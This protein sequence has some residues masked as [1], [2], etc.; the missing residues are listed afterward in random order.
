MASGI[1]IGRP[2]QI[3][4]ELILYRRIN[5]KLEKENKLLKSE[6]E[7]LKEKLKS[8]ETEFREYVN[9]PSPSK[10]YISG[11]GWRK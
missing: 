4:N 3:R 6:C 10:D 11:G 2:D 7:D 9:R 8:L 5:R 1:D